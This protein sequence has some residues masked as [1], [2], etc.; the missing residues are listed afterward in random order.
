VSDEHGRV[1]PKGWVV[2]TLGEIAE[3]NPLF[4]RSITDDRMA[5]AFVPMRAVEPEGGGVIRPETRPYGEVKKGF[6]SFLPGDV[7]MAK[8]T[9]CMENGKIAVVPE[10]LGDVAFG[11]TEFHVIRPRAGIAPSWIA[12]FLLQRDVRRLAQREM[13]GAVGQMRVP[14]SFLE[15]VQIPV[16]PST[17]QARV[18]DAL[19][20]LFSELDSG[21]ASLRLVQE[22][23][24]L[25]RATLLKTAAS[26]ELTAEWRTQH[27]QTE[28]AAEL[29]ERILVE[30][31]RRWEEEHLAK[32]KA[33]GQEPP[34]NW[35]AKYKQ[36]L[37]ADIANLPSLPEGWC[38]ATL[39]QI[40]WSSGYG[41]SQ[42]CRETNTGVAVLR[43]PNVV[44]GRINLSDLKFAPPEYSERDDD[45]VRVGDMLV[46]RT[47]GSRSLIGRGAVVREAPPI[48]L[49]F[50]S[51]LI[52]LRIIPYAMVLDW[53]ALLWDSLHVRRWIET[54][55]AT[56]A[57]QFNINLRVLHTLVVPIP[58]IA[59]QEAIVEAVDDQISIIDHL[60]GNVD[61]KLKSAHSLRQSVLRHA[62]TGRLV[63]QDPSDEP[64]SELLTRIAAHREVQRARAAQGRSPRWQSTRKRSSH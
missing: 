12:R 21:V 10:L 38:W 4:K 16:A 57:G 36:P 29:L 13:T 22:K 20:E 58:P 14:P 62:F 44:G 31:R 30:R 15:S 54:R 3:I 7:I 17:E 45:L 48:R 61:A 50:A 6:T 32:F 8:I 26:G 28:P 55:A 25:Y 33:K 1:V 51:Y 23:L 41:T 52:R 35:K 19:D 39:D 37:A 27:P 59:E 49:T 63:P 34:K 53:V 40:A 18:A 5:V 60:E 2:Q 42:K 56:S 47:N 9:P 24:K 46:V 64:A 11:S 43:I